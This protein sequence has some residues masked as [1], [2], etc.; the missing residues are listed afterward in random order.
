[1]LPFY[2]VGVGR[3]GCVPL[4]VLVVLGRIGHRAAE[5]D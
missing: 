5:K 4:Q 2:C 1:M 3:F